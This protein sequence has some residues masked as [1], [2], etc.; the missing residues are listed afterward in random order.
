MES[1][2]NATLAF[3]GI[4]KESEVVTAPLPGQF[5]VGV[6][7][8]AVVLRVGIHIDGEVAS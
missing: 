6:D 4:E 2:T 7:H 5:E 3:I 8:I 1:E